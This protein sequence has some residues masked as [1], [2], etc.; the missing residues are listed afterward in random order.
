MTTQIRNSEMVELLRPDF[1]NRNE[2]NFA[3]G[4]TIS[5]FRSLTGLRGFW[6][7]GSVDENGDVYDLSNQ[8]R[9]LTNNNTV[10]FDYDG[11]VPYVQ[12]VNASSQF[13]DRPD[14]VGLSITGT[15]A[16]IVN[17]GITFGGWFWLDNLTTGQVLIG[18]F[19]TNGNQ[20]SYL[21]QYN[22]AANV[23]RL[24]MSVDGTATS[25]TDSTVT[26]TANQWIFM[27]GRLETGSEESIFVNGTKTNQE[28]GIAGIFDSTAT[29]I[30]GALN[31]GGASLLDGRAS[32]NFLCVGA[33]SDA[34]IQTL[35]QQSR[36]MYGV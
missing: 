4:N 5:M 6:S 21:L 10:T 35:F 36:A 7:M 17:S 8:G 14:E 29:F 26:P 13:L 25:L 32:M 24:N 20:R 12:F 19:D 11:L 31:A 23:L 3:W 16:E 30:V 22:F 34:I 1:Q 9:T 33:L 2:P 15:E 28:S 27:V 18:K